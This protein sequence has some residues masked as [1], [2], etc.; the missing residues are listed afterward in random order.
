MYEATGGDGKFTVTPEL[1]QSY[2][3]CRDLIHK[4]IMNT[5][6]R[7]NKETH[8]Y[9]DASKRA[10]CVI[11][12]QDG[13]I[14][15]CYSRA[16]NTAERKYCPMEL[17]LLAIKYGCK[18]L[19][20]YRVQGMLLDIAEF[21]I[22]ILYTLKARKMFLLIWVQGMYPGMMMKIWFCWFWLLETM[23]N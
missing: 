4:D 11:L 5:H 7:D 22:V 6:F 14:V 8:M 19:R 20:K 13:K 15:A 16:L 10:L 9:F 1:I 17:E 2:E 18:K 3:K 12:V 21:D 23:N